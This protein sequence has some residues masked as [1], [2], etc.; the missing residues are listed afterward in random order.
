MFSHDQLHPVIPHGCRI[1]MLYIIIVYRSVKAWFSSMAIEFSVKPGLQYR[2]QC[3]CNFYTVIA[4]IAQ[5][6]EPVLSHIKLT[7]LLHKDTF[8]ELLV[9]TSFLF[10]R[11]LFRNYLLAQ[12]K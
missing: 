12:R 9:Y 7:N 3:R 11:D 10:L 6:S 5:Y 2:A 8:Q 1:Q 4:H